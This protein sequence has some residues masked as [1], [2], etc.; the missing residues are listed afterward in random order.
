MS[1]PERTGRAR[2]D[3]GCRWCGSK[4][5]TVKYEI[6]DP[7]SGRIGSDVMCC[8]CGKEQ[9]RWGLERKFWA[10]E[11]CKE[12]FTGVLV[13]AWLAAQIIRLATP[14]DAIPALLRI[15]SVAALV[16]Q[17]AGYDRA[18][19]VDHLGATTTLA[20]PGEVTPE[21]L[22]ASAAW[23]RDLG[24]PTCGRGAIRYWGVAEAIAKLRDQIA[25]QPAPAAE[26]EAWKH[27]LLFD[28]EAS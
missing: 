3:R 25:P 21:L 7:E 6:R 2:P 19:I 8:V 13:T 9:W 26:P 10:E 11:T 27:G 20:D 24:C 4:A 17:R 12:I 18:F 16:L 23:F 28:L 14:T 15:R 5:E 22:T 1:I